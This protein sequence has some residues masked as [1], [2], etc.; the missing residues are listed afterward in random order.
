MYDDFRNGAD[1][2]TNLITEF[3]QSFYNKS[4]LIAI[5]RAHKPTINFCGNSNLFINYLL[6]NKIPF[7]IITDG[8]SITQRNKIA[9]LG[10]DNLLA[11]LI[12][13]E[14]FGSE[15]PNE[16]NYLY[17]EDRFAGSEFTY[18][19]D[20]TGKDF[21]APEKLGWQMVCLKDN[22]K[23]IHLQNLDLLHPKT[24]LIEDFTE[25]IIN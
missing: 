19:A 18:I 23:N 5:Y 10:L 17:F 12:I 11:G 24:I 1:V 25:L 15:K 7:G 14:E 3:P 13:S 4:D 6:D 20:N 16:K 9:A 22:G 2:F 8:R 21:I